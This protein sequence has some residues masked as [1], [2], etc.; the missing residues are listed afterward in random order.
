VPEQRQQLETFAALTAMALERVHYVDVAQHATVQMETE[1]LRNS[2]L[3]ALSH[4]LRTPLAALVGL[5]ESLALNG[6]PLAGAQHEAALAI[7]D[8]ARRMSALVNNLLQMARIQ[9]GE[10]QLRLQWQ[11]LEEVVGSAL[12]SAHA[13][14]AQHPIQVALPPDLPLVEFDATLIERVLANL[15]ENA[16]KYT[17]AGTVVRISARI[18]GD[19]LEVTVAD[20]GPGL[21]PGQ[22]EAI[23]EKF[24]RGARESATPGVG[25]GLAISRAIVAAHKGH[26][27]AE[28]DPTGGARFSFTLPART[29]PAVP[30]EAA[31]PAGA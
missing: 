30:D 14:L 22:E 4:D 18:A 13:A 28:S 12:K 7:A 25:L 19:M 20:R 17:P 29:P 6:P 31:D 16:G 24:T 2:L 26:I 10:V 8:E 5:A 11:P 15:L 23:F 27:W 21:P 3:S 1:R 9:S